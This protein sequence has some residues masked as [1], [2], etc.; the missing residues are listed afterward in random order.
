[1]ICYGIFYIQLGHCTGHWRLETG[2]KKSWTC[3]GN[4]ELVIV[5]LHF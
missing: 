3:D 4:F 5:F 2:E 1:M